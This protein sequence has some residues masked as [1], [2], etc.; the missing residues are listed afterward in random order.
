[1]C[2]CNSCSLVIKYYQVNNK[3][4]L[5]MCRDGIGTVNEEL[6]RLDE[7]WMPMPKNIEPV[8]WPGKKCQEA[9]A[10]SSPQLRKHCYKTPQPLLR[11]GTVNHVALF[12]FTTK[13]AADF[14]NKMARGSGMSLRAKGYDYY[15]EIVKC[16]LPQL[17]CTNS[18]RVHASFCTC[19]T[20]YYN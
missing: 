19:A 1:M 2:A 20:V 13:S 8:Q 12:H 4:K 17:A 7:V 11:N 14:K 3:Q 10:S 9:L 16:V 6:V 18:V 15:N 5:L